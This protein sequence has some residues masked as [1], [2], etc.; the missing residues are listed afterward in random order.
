MSI[1]IFVLSK[2]K[3]EIPLSGGLE[4]ITCVS[5]SNYSSDADTKLTLPYKHTCYDTE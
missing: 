1:K 4:N 5:F 2:S 3:A